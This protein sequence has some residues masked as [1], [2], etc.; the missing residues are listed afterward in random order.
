MKAH[1]LCESYKPT[2]SL[3]EEMMMGPLIKSHATDHSYW[4]SRK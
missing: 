3:Y 1:E 4:D 2:F